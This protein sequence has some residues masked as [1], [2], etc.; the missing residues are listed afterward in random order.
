MRAQ[1]RTRVGIILASCLALLASLAVAGC[2]GKKEEPKPAAGPA[3]P[4]PATEEPLPPLAY[5]SGLPEAVRA[6]LNEVFTGDL[7]EMVKR[8]LVRVGVTFNH[9]LYFVD[10]GVQRGAAYEYVKLMEDELNKRRKTGNLRVVFWFVPLPRDQLLPALVDGKVDMVMAQL[11][12]TPERQQRVDFTNPTRKDVNEVVVTGPGAPAITSVDD[13]SGQQVFVRKTSSYYQSLLALNERLTAAGKPPVSIEEA[14]E[15]LE[16]EDLL[17]MV[18][19][20]LIKIIVVDNYL[21]DFWKKVFE[22]LTVHDTVAVRT[23]GHLAVAIRK[24]SPQLA[25]GL[26]AIIDEYGLGTAF[27]NMM[28]KRYLQNTKFV[29]NATS[30]AERQRFLAL[31]ELF[32][33]YSDQYGVDYLLMAAQG[34]QESGLDQGVKSPVGAVGVMQVMPATGK[35]LKVGDISQ[36]EPNIHAGVKYMRWV[37]DNYYKDEPMDPLNKGLFA[38]ASYNAGPG[39]IRQLRKEA[40]KRGLDPN[41]WFGNVE[42]IASERIGRETVTYVSNIYKY[43]IAYRLVVAEKERRDAAKK[44]LEA[45]SGK[46]AQ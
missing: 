39:R 45:A 41:V 22:D 18:N 2:S 13:L 9:T 23:G 26:N 5:E 33:K 28:E 6:E 4:A 12:V 46:P 21:A 40:E 30:E 8:R 35:D 32:K 1:V 43:Y 11:T 20:G 25:A 29:K 7:D 38:F 16:D 24:G 31:V 14:P 3:A 42:Q 37:V 34:Y 36:L 15:N 27:G 10:Q 19:A 17:E 44:A